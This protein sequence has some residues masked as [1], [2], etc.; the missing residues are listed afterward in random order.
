LAIPWWICHQQQW[1]DLNLQHRSCFIYYCWIEI[2]FTSV[3]THFRLHLHWKY[4]IIGRQF[5]S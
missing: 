1:W 2:P 4:S 3:D 5:H